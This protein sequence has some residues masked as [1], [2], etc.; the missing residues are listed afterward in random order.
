[1]NLII[2]KS[3]CCAIK[4]ILNLPKLSNS[5]K[6]RK[7]SQNKTS[8]PQPQNVLWHCSLYT[9]YYTESGRC[10]EDGSFICTI[11]TQRI[12]ECH[13]LTQIIISNEY[14]MVSV[15]IKENICPDAS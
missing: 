1:M 14:D 11:C 7:Q 13:M 9:F 12:D 2:V 4:V 10:I 5:D 3:Q 6:T 8:P 15:C